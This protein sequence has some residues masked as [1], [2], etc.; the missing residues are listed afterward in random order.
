ME[1]VSIAGGV[2]RRCQSDLA[3]CIWL[4]TLDDA[5]LPS[6]SQSS[7]SS[8]A[9]P[10]S[11]TMTP[12]SAGGSSTGST[13]SAPAGLSGTS[14]SSSCANLVP[15]GSGSD[16]CPLT[17]TTTSTSTSAVAQQ[18]LARTFEE[19]VSRIRPEVLLPWLP[20]L[21]ICLLRPEGR[22]VCSA[23]R[24]LIAAYP[25]AVYQ[26]LRGLQHQLAT[27]VCQDETVAQYLIATATTA[28]DTGFNGSSPN[29]AS[30]D[31]DRAANADR[32][33]PLAASKTG[34]IPVS[35][36]GT[37]VPTD[38]LRQ[39]RRRER[40][41]RAALLRPETRSAYSSLISDDW[42][43][44]LEADRSLVRCPGLDNSIFSFING[45]LICN[46]NRQS[47]TGDPIICLLHSSSG[48]VNEGNTGFG[49][50]SLNPE[51][52]G[53]LDV[54]SSSSSS[55][56][57]CSSGSALAA[58]LGGSSGQAGTVS[59]LAAKRQ[60]KKVVVVM[61]GVEGDRTSNSASALG[62]G[63][64]GQLG[65]GVSSIGSSGAGNMGSNDGLLSCLDMS[66]AEA[67]KGLLLGPSSLATSITGSPLNQELAIQDSC[68][69]GDEDDDEEVATNI[70]IAGAA[71]LVGCDETIES[72]GDADVEASVSGKLQTDEETTNS[73]SLASVSSSSS[74]APV[75]RAALNPSVSSTTSFVA[76]PPVRTTGY[77]PVY[78]NDWLHRINV[79]ISQLR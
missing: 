71:T 68:I 73:V 19:R 48:S 32:S 27:E 26:A 16:S 14:S 53:S 79:L 62:H 75:A 43:A 36:S 29:T 22:F 15:G 63:H 20:S 60:K 44:C 64:P 24:S 7:F 77:L 52:T 4:L 45:S 25:T 78:V 8:T 41:L 57:T 59:G 30:E 2:E 46:D 9:V 40:R 21:V 33:D 28:S 70:A 11:S 76:A 74:T 37:A 1:A 51:G 5:P 72:L 66:S 61:R 56:S 55:S 67:G 13:C 12:A 58:S 38:C 69:G 23:L 31:T 54:A 34:H 50:Q 18:R 65:S 39:L 3:K 49:V 17:S 35:T 10:N 47:P 42:L 6:P